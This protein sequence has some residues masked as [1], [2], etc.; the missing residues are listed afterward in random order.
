MDADNDI[1]LIELHREKLIDIKRTQATI[2]DDLLTADLDV[3]NLSVHIKLRSCLLHLL[4][5]LQH[6]P[7]LLGKE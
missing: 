3:S 5:M 7:P 2:H 1:S 6:S 4:R